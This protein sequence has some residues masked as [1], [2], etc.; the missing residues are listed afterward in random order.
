MH[1]EECNY[2]CE[3]IDC[4]DNLEKDYE[5]KFSLGIRKQEN[6]AFD[7]ILLLNW[8]DYRTYINDMTSLI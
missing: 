2:K 7:I 3:L 6:L 5:Q 8:N 1:F 4:F